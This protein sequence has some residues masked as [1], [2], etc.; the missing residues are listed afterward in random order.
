MLGTIRDVLKVKLI[1]AVTFQPRMDLSQ[2]IKA[3]QSI[4][5][6]VDDQ[7]AI[8]DFSF[9]DYYKEEMGTDLKKV[10]LSFKDL[11]HPNELPQ[12]KLKTNKLENQW[13]EKGK[14]KVNLDSGYV[15]GA[16]L[17]LASTKDFAH[18]VFIGEGIYGDVQL[19]FRQN[20]FWPNEWTYP[21]YQTELAFSFFQKVRE[22]LIQQSQ[23]EKVNGL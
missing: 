10:F 8:F 3:L 5:G 11:Y 2:V 16:K 21:D 15:T 22:K 6:S 7:S 17:V 1:C 9:S 13:S 23:N 20:R 18:R 4:L 19:R 12:I 14:R